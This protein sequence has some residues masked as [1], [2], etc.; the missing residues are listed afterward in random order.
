MPSLNAAAHFVY[1]CVHGAKSGWARLKWLADVDRVARGLSDEE[2]AEATQIFEAHGLG[3]IGAAS[4]SLS[5]KVLGTPIPP[6][7]SEMT[8]RHDPRRLIKLQLPMIFGEMPAKPHSLKDWRHFRDRFHHSLIL[9]GGKGYRRH[10][11]L[12]EVAR[13]RD[14]ESISLSPKT[15]WAL[16]VISP[17]LGIGRALSRKFGSK[18]G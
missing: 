2:L 13:P 18:K 7:F 5:H 12:R 10:A 15:L 6:A 17:V 9:H 3:R 14:L 4:L 11:L 16:G 8:K 1:I